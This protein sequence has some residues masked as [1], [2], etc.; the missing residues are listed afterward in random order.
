MQFFSEIQTSSFISFRI[1]QSRAEHPLFME[2]PSSKQTPL[3]PLLVLEV[4]QLSRSS[5]FIPWSVDASQL[6][7]S[8]ACTSQGQQ[9]IHLIRIN[10]NIRFGGSL[11]PPAGI[12]Q[13]A[14]SPT[15]QK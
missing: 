15:H 9:F 5:I 4:M 13:L 14:I 10:V 12:Y 1:E 3:L 6:R 8:H 7:Y 11:L 2:S